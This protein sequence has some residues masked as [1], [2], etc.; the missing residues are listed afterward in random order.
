MAFSF[1]L[2]K[3]LPGP[4]KIFQHGK[5]MYS[6]NFFLKTVFKGSQSLLLRWQNFADKILVP[7]H[8]QMRAR[9][10]HLHPIC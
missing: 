8:I 3:H 7:I 5:I 9:G 6:V 10:F 2:F 4:G 1:F